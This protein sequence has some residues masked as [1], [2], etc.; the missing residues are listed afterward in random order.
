[1]SEF[2]N[3]TDLGAHADRLVREI[4]S[5]PGTTEVQLTAIREAHRIL[6]TT[7]GRTGSLTTILGTALQLGIPIED[8]VIRLAA[9]EGIP[10][11][12]VGQPSPYSSGTRSIL[13]YGDKV[14]T[15]PGPYSGT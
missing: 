9:K 8:E 2:I 11:T 14:P 7:D 5:H 6:R 12:A 10:I 13:R 4:E 3:R 15:Q 1:M